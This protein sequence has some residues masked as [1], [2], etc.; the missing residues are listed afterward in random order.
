MSTYISATLGCLT[1]IAIWAYGKE[2]RGR[3]R[4]REPLWRKDDDWYDS[5]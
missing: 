1:A 3:W 2:L 5:W 4:R